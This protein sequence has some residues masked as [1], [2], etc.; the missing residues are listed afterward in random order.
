M[1]LYHYT[2]TG[3]EIQRGQGVEREAGGIYTMPGD[4]GSDLEDF[5]QIG[6]HKIIEI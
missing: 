4:P 6:Y 2:G 1:C 3:R 5:R